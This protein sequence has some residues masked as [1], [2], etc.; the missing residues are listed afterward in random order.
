MHLPHQHYT[1]PSQCTHTPP[2]QFS[3]T[4][5]Y[6][7]PGHHVL[8]PLPYAYNALEKV[9]DER[10]LRIHHDKHHRKYVEDLNKAELSLQAA[11]TNGDF[12]CI[13]H[14]EKELAFNGSGHILHSLYWTSMSPSDSGGQPH[15][16]TQAYLDR[17]FGGVPH[18]WAQFSAAANAVEG[19]GWC[20]LCYN[21]YF[22]SLVILQAEKHQNLTQWGVV[23]LLV[24]DVWEHAYYLRYQNER[25]QYVKNWFALVNWPEV[26]LRLAHFLAGRPDQR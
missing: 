23:P 25:A 6:V 1:A 2:P 8:P 22:R 5:H 20:A 9:I 11:L 21:P 12:T 24:C 16:T 14:W 17:D 26:E 18:F 13:K 15:P 4:T 19:S 3:P 10:T 7:P